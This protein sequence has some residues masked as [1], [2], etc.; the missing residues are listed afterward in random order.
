MI[1]ILTPDEMTAVDTAAV[2]GGTSL[3]TLIDRAGRA[4]ALEACRC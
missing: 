4:V 3:E 2:A 1:P